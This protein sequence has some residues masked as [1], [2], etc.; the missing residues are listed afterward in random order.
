MNPIIE[1]ADK[2]MQYILSKISQSFTSNNVTLFA[3]S[4]LLRSRTAYT[5][6]D[7]SDNGPSKLPEN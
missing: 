1:K 2:H 6:S 7:S 4:S 3:C 5:I